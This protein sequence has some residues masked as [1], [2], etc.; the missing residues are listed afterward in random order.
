MKTM[1]K[2]FLLFFCVFYELTWCLFLSQHAAY[3]FLATIFLGAAAV[4]A[5]AGGA[6]GAL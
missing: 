6:V 1:K 3:F 2:Y 5:A 4:A